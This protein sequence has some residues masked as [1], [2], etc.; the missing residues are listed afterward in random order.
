MFHFIF[1]DI[2][3]NDVRYYETIPEVFEL[4]SKVPSGI[5][6]SIFDQI[7]LKDFVRFQKP[8]VELTEDPRYQGI[9]NMGA[10]CYMNAA[11]QQLFWIQ[12]FRDQLFHATV[13]SDDWFPEFQYLFSE[14]MF[15]PS[16]WIDISYFVQKWMG[17]D[18]SPVNP[19]E[20]ADGLEFSQLL[21]ERLESK[22]ASS[23]RLFKG[24]LKHVIKGQDFS[25]DSEEDFMTLPLE[26]KGYSN[27]GSSLK[28]F[29]SPIHYDD[30]SVDRVG[31]VKADT[32]TRIS[33]CPE[34]LIVQL[35]RFEYNIALGQRE[36]L[37]DRFVFPFEF[38][39]LPVTEDE[40][41][42]QIY[43]LVGIIVHS[44][45]ATGG[46]Y[47]SY[48]RV[49]D[50]W[51]TFDDCS[52]D[53]AD[54]DAL[55]ESCAGGQFSTSL[56]D[57]YRTITMIDE[58]NTTSAYILFYRKRQ[59]QIRDP[60]T[61]NPKILERLLDNIKKTL[62]KEVFS[63]LLFSELVF[64]HINSPH[65]LY[66]YMVFVMRYNSSKF[67]PEILRRVDTNLQFTN[68]VLTGIGALTDFLL[69]TPDI[70]IRSNYLAV[71][72]KAIKLGSTQAKGNLVE[73]VC[74]RFLTPEQILPHWQN[75]DHFFRPLLCLVQRNEGDETWV[76]FL[77]PFFADRV[78][79]YLE[80]ADYATVNLTAIL[81]II[82]ALFPRAPRFHPGMLDIQFFANLLKNPSHRPQTKTLVEFVWACDPSDSSGL[83][84]SLVHESLELISFFFV[85]VINLGRKKQIRMFIRSII[86]RHLDDLYSLFI[87]LRTILPANATSFA[88]N[89]TQFAGKLMRN[90]LLSCGPDI[91][92]ATYCLITELFERAPT[93]K[94]NRL[95]RLLLDDLENITKLDL[96]IADDRCY[97]R[98]DDSTLEQQMNA[99]RY[100]QILK[101]LADHGDVK[102]LIIQNSHRLVGAI[103]RLGSNLFASRSRSTCFA[104]IVESLRGQC[105]EFFS[106]ASYADF[107]RGFEHFRYR[108][109]ANSL[110]IRLEQFVPVDGMPIFVKSTIFD[111]LCPLMF[112][113]PDAEKTHG[114][115]WQDFLLSHMTPEALHDGMSVIWGTELFATCLLGY[116]FLYLQTTWKILKKFPRAATMFHRLN[117]HVEIYNEIVRGSIPIAGVK[118]FAR[119]LAQFNFS[120]A[121]VNFRNS[122]FFGRPLNSNLA[123]FY[124]RD[125]QFTGLLFRCLFIDAGLVR[126]ESG[127]CRMLAS[128][129]WLSATFTADIFQMLAAMQP[130]FWQRLPLN[131]RKWAPRFLATICHRVERSENVAELLLREFRSIAESRPIEYRG[132][133]EFSRELHTVLQRTGGGAASCVQCISVVCEVAVDIERFPDGVLELMKVVGE[134][135]DAIAWTEAIMAQALARIR[136]IL[137]TDA[138]LA[139][140][141]IRR[142][143]QVIKALG[144]RFADLDWPT[145][146]VTWHEL[147]Q[148]AILMANSPDDI[149]NSTSILIEWGDRKL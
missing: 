134:L 143:D 132:L 115:E 47:F 108:T 60:S 71:V 138:A 16:K 24:R 68:L 27:L 126:G 12:E 122:T 61:F 20:Q 97:G 107:L 3:L 117:R 111:R 142:T 7:D 80:P 148:W 102:D 1:T 52:V 133:G 96:Q 147:N 110:L 54:R 9:K 81:D 79:S 93:W 57:T 85:V 48:I 69:E 13:E 99:P 15:F 8:G 2:V 116:P 50:E 21:F 73:G 32:Y 66:N 72:D 131:S 87:E 105:D 65:F 26:V 23:T 100:F 75:F 10:T 98:I 42:E 46:H 109:T 67:L 135:H 34:I 29:S 4:L 127:V 145:M 63:S 43:E 39:L 129:A 19:G 77:L 22:F 38:D 6:D 103:K 55:I 92:S 70:E 88:E 58:P 59:Q 33:I 86:G 53:S 144:R 139:G 51:T 37:H 95:F 121:A 123:E 146:T 125:R 45:F 56:T 74:E 83:I 25:Q 120:Y 76:Q 119:V 31:K 35:Q 49:N 91:C 140:R 62:W 82:V 137:R 18:G 104:F 84:G 78:A 136:V 130:T 106:H 112:T 113:E 94:P 28:A 64:S 128:L 41:M 149:M 141:I 30:Y 5:I 17:W 40:E 124:N 14:L 114:G 11:I 101:E 118:L 89:M 36:K 90:A 44:G